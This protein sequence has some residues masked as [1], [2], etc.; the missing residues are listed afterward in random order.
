[1]NLYPHDF[2]FA[3][4]V[5]ISRGAEHMSLKTLSARL[6]SQGTA[7][8]T[9]GL[10]RIERFE[11]RVSIGEASA[12]AEALEQPTMTINLDDAEWMPAR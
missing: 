11:R 12:I 8:A 9:L 3:R 4:R 2:E 10:R 5:R 6:C 7:I 1:M